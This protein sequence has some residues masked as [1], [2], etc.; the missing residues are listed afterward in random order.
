MNSPVIAETLAGLA[1]SI[2]AAA[3]LIFAALAMVRTGTAVFRLVLEQA[4]R[5]VRQEVVTDDRN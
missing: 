5:Q 2:I 3:L 1:L 4:R